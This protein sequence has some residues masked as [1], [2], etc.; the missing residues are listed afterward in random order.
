VFIP[1]RCGLC[2]EHCPNWMY[3]NQLSILAENEIY[4][5]IEDEWD[6]WDCIECGI[7][8]Y[9]CPA[10]RPIIHFIK[11]AKAIVDNM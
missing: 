10:H 5:T 6:L 8:A 9:V 2:V 1:R 3:P 11:Q 7:C 4:D